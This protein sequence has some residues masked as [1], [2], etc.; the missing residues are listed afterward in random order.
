MS[1][2]LDPRN[3]QP[4]PRPDRADDDAPVVYAPVVP[5]KPRRGAAAKAASGVKQSAPAA[6]AIPPPPR[7]ATASGRSRTAGVDD[8][9]AARILADDDDAR[10]GLPDD[11]YRPPAKHV[12]YPGRTNPR[13]GDL[14]MT[15]LFT[16]ALYVIAVVYVVDAVQRDASAARV[17]EG[18]QLSSILAI[19]A[20]IV[21]AVFSTVFSALFILRRVPA[22]WLPVI[23]SLLIVALYSVTQQMLDTAVIHSF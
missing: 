21:L 16:L 9:P 12:R 4:A 10:P 18:V 22:F 3:Q 23:A 1:T 13:R 7:G 20:P 15:A 2:P 19:G 6:P 11:A 5:R 8:D 14:V 17:L